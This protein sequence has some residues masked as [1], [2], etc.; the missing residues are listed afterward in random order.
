MHQFD[1]LIVD[2]N[3][4]NPLQDNNLQFTLIYKDPRT[5]E[6]VIKT[7]EAPSY[8]AGRVW[9]VCWFCCPKIIETNLMINEKPHHPSRFFSYYVKLGVFFKNRR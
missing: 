8:T 7:F 5:Y 3:F 2:R 6:Y 1:P 4:K 9:D